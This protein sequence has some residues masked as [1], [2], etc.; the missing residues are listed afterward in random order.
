MFLKCCKST[1]SHLPST[2]TWLYLGLSCLRLGELTNAEDALSQANI[3][4]HLNPR[5]W[6]LMTVLCLNG[7]N[8]LAQAQ[9]C[10][11]EALRLGLEDQ[12]ILDEIGDMA[13]NDDQTYSLAIQS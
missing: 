8:R 10:F 3:L 4:D 1:D 2:T 11:A 6:G 12:E 13:K 5:V 9:M 7:K